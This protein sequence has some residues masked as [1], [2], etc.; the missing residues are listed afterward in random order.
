LSG[1]GH[2]R[3]YCLAAVDPRSAR[4]FSGCRITEIFAEPFWGDQ[5]RA[6]VTAAW[7]GWEMAMSEFKQQTIALWILL[8]LLLMVPWILE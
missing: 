8:M 3:A 7:L 5:I 6:S 4:P 1:N 2:L